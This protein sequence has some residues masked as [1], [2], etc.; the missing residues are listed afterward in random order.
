MR[1]KIL[2]PD[3]GPLFSFAAVEGGLELILAADLQIVLTDYIEWEATRSQ[4]G[5]ALAIARWIGDN[6]KSITVIETERGQQRIAIERS[7]ATTKRNRKNVGEQT[8]FEAIS[9]GDVGE[10]PFLFLFEEDQFVDPGFYGRYPVHSVSTLG[11]LCGL[12]KSGVIKD[13]EGIFR[14]MRSNGREG[15]KALILDRPYRRTRD[16]EDTTW[17]P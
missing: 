5:S 1:I 17:R 2:L 4:S 3:A 7:G 10:G 11:F 13:A 16:G 12:E 14:S 9:E 8:I 6:P 15:V